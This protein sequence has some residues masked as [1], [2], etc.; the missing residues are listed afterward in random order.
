MS[1][2]SVRKIQG[3][4]KTQTRRPKYRDKGFA[5]CGDLLWVKEP[6][7]ALLHPDHRHIKEREQVAPGDYVVYRADWPHIVDDWYSSMFMPRW[8]SRLSLRVLDVRE[9]WLQDISPQDIAAEGFASKKDFRE[10]WD[11]LHKTRQDWA[12]W[13]CNPK[14]WVVDFEVM[15]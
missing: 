1:V 14:V 2:H 9:E 11:T 3:R 5:N 4:I 8:A 6:W 10:T 13:D 7:A 12:M 15:G